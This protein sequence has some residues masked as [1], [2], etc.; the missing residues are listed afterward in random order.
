MA[1]RAFVRLE[2]HRLRT[3][4]SWY[5]TKKTIIRNAVRQYLKFPLIRATSTA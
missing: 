2:A 4:L 1:V 5:E 3:G